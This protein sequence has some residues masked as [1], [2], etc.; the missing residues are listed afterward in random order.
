MHFDH[1]NKYQLLLANTVLGGGMSS[2]LHQN[3][4]E[5]MAIAIPY[6]VLINPIPIQ[7]YGE[8]M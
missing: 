3:V 7:E 5:N 6:K 8:F 1:E 2:R 4:R